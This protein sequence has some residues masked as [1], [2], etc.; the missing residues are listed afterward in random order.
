M[1]G[2][3][4]HELPPKAPTSFSTAHICR[5]Y[6]SLKCSNFELKDM[7][8]IDLPQA[9][10]TSTRVVKCHCSTRSAHVI[11]VIGR[12][13]C[14]TGDASLIFVV[15]PLAFPALNPVGTVCWSHAQCTTAV[16][17]DRRWLA[18]SADIA[19]ARCFQFLVCTGLQ[20]QL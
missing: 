3:P 4:K 15:R 10:S 17:I 19:L 11:L 8:V 13:P 16:A 18:V 20:S 6:P 2:L 12:T 14:I 5:Q 7:I 1:R 9:P